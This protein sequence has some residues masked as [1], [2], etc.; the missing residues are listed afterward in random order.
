M[1]TF[2]SENY[3]TVETATYEGLFE[4]DRGTEQIVIKDNLI[5]DATVG[6]ARARAELLKGGYVERWV[7]ITSI[8]ITGLIQNDIISFKGL[9]W[10]VKEISLDFTSP[11][12]VQNIKG[13]RYE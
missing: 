5:G 7:S 13:V 4:H 11:K 10:I 8:Q 2:T 3:C 6:E 9:N 1:A 12:L